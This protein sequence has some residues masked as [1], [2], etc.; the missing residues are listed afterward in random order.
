[1]WQFEMRVITLHPFH[2][3]GSIYISKTALDEVVLVFKLLE[4]KL[5][6]IFSDSLCV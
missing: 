6:L 2:H 3:L 4:A 1:M 5:L